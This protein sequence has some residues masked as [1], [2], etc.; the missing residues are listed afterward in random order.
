[1]HLLETFFSHLHDF[2]GIWNPAAAQC[3][4]YWHTHYPASTTLRLA[5]S[6]WQDYSGSLG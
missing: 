5:P 2:P 6:I 3:A 1:M 4:Q